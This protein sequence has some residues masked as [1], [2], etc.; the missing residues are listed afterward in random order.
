MFAESVAELVRNPREEARWIRHKYEKKLKEGVLAKEYAATEAQIEAEKAEGLLTTEE[1]VQ[2]RRDDPACL[3]VDRL[4]IL[5]VI[6]QCL[7]LLQTS[8]LLLLC[9]KLIKDNDIAIILEEW[10]V[11]VERV[12]RGG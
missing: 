11:G 12:L 3:V 7:S 6:K 10:H 9:G 1:D 2:K 8:H 5:V 4:S